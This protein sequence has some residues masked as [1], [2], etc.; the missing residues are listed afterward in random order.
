MTA[1][2]HSEQIST[3][4]ADEVQD[5]LHMVQTLLARQK[6]VEAL[7]H[8]QEMPRHELVEDVLHKQHLAELRVKLEHM[9]PAR[10]ARILEAL[11]Q[12]ECLQVWELV[13][14]ERG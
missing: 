3:S 6:R 2:P 12:D 1:P 5:S 7:V 9:A 10:I 4:H 8:R 14:K 11:P 13:A